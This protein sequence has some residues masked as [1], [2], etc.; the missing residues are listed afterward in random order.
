M[1]YTTTGTA[2]LSVALLVALTASTAA[3]Q[4]S[5]TAARVGVQTPTL[6]TAGSSLDHPLPHNT[7]EALDKVHGST[8][9]F[10]LW[11]DS[12][13]YVVQ[14]TYKD[15]WFAGWVSKKM[16]DG[17]F[18]KTGQILW[19]VYESVDGKPFGKTIGY[20]GLPLPK[21]GFFGWYKNGHWILS[22]LGDA[23]WVTGQ[24]LTWEQ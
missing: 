6:A 17:K 14:G 9:A 1:K 10:A 7:Q 15:G 21:N 20:L 18:H 4:P 3:A 8:H 24:F 11:D 16:N 5:L 23:G 22:Q 13:T 19:G 12:Q 2:L